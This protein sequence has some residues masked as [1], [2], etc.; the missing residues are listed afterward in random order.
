LWLP[1]WS[2]LALEKDENMTE[3]QKIE[4]FIQVFNDEIGVFYDDENGEKEFRKETLNSLKD[5]KF[6]FLYI[7]AN[8]GEWWFFKNK[9]ELSDTATSFL[10]GLLHH[11]CCSLWAYDID[12]QEE[13][14]FKLVTC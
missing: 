10:S 5:S 4:K 9:E 1:I 6:L 7:N 13:I 8:G 12:S 14:G 11:E 3:K 2:K